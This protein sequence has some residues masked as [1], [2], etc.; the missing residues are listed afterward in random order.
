MIHLFTRM[1]MMMMMMVRR[2]IV[3]RDR[4][5]KHELIHLVYRHQFDLN[6]LEYGL[7]QVRLVRVDVIE[8][9]AFVKERL[10]RVAFEAIEA[11]EERASVEM[12]M[13][14]VLERELVRAGNARKA[15]RD[16]LFVVHAARFHVGPWGRRALVEI[17]VN[18]VDELNA[19][20]SEIVF[21]QVLACDVACG[22]D[23]RD[24]IVAQLVFVY[25]CC[26]CRCCCWQSSIHVAAASWYYWGLIR[27]CRGLLFRMNLMMVMLLLLLMMVMS[28][29]HRVS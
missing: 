4:I 21:V 14:R 15:H 8:E 27:N 22:E 9:F 26:S 13:E 23:T 2:V 1:I 29:C 10:V 24:E 7:E 28:C 5:C 25:C 20:E 11:D 16:G 6:R 3:I 18:E 12:L 17:E 19:I